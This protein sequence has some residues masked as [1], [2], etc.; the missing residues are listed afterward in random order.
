[1][2]VTIEQGILSKYNVH[3]SSYHGGKMEG[4]STRQL[5]HNGKEIFAD[6]AEYI[7]ITLCNEDERDKMNVAQD[8]K[9]NTICDMTG[10]L[11]LLLD[12]VFAHIYS[13]H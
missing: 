2:R 13:V 3:M 5:M 8:K 10:L 6:I 7:K 12:S 11:F 9:I 1:M 4:P